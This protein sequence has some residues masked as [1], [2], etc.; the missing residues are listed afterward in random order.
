MSVEIRAVFSGRVQGV[1]FRVTVKR[2]AE[3]HSVKGY[4]KNLAD[5]C[6]ELLAQGNRLNIEQLMSEIQEDLFPGYITKVELQELPISIH[7]D[8][9]EIR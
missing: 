8:A 2:A 9:F 1:G 6:V 3:R 5:G 4:A 7:Y